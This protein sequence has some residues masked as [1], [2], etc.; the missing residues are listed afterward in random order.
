[1][2]EA[3]HSL[4]LVR[5]GTFEVDLQAGE[6][7]KSGLKLK[8]TGQPFQVLAILLERAGEVVTREEMQ[9]RLWPDTFV[10]VDHNLNT[11]INKI[12]EVLGDSAE[13]P[14]FVETL[15]RRGY[16]FIGTI[17]HEN[18]SASVSAGLERLKRFSTNLVVVAVMLLVVV[19]SA[20]IWLARKRDSAMTTAIRSIAVLPLANLSGD[21]Q[22]D[23]LADGVTEELIATLGKLSALRVISRT[24]VMRYKNTDKPLPQI[25][26][27]LNVDAVVEGSAQREGNRVRITAQLIHASTDR[28]LWAETYD[29]DLRDILTVESEVAQTIANEVRIK[30]TPQEQA[31][32]ASAPPV[33]PE[34]RE[35]YLKGRYYWNKRTPETAKKSLDYFQR[36]IEKD[37]GYA[38][39]YSA[40]ADSYVVLGAYKVL[41]PKLAYPKAEAAAMRAL[42]ADNRLG[43]AHAA[44]GVSKMLFDWNW[45][46]AE[47]EFK[48]AIELSPNYA[49]AYHWYA[50]YL[51]RMGRHTEAITAA[52]KAESLDPLSLVNS[53]DLGRDALGPA[54]LYE[55]ELQQCRKTLEMD[56]NFASAHVCLADSY[57]RKG[58]YKEAIAELQRANETS[59]GG[60][61]LA[62]ALGSAF[63]R[64]GRR[65][66]A[67]KILNQLEARSK[68]EFV[69][70]SSFAIMYGALG[71]R[72]QAFLWLE[73]G[74]E[75]HDTEMLN[76][77]SSPEFDPLRSD[78]RFEDLVRRMNLPQ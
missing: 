24:S 34:V 26:K 64:A 66:E 59:G 1:V 65:D 5:F 47:R 53:A 48:Q 77:R 42:E 58:M 19:V 13:N 57:R 72:D 30:L 44:L 17:N 40:L 8:L 46:G 36:A 29:R 20:A 32:L 18:A 62:P 31:G 74:Y 71:Q 4:S 70:A 22:Q 12:R 76:L 27:E 61:T 67:I 60:L 14:R 45:D 78:A 50:L 11:A 37:P 54:G 23:Y 39:A 56:P 52:R 73:K 2:E 38:P 63:A 6:L 21:P 68:R 55:Q 69:P 15:P 10:D 33:S 35:L 25:A 9:K 7:R 49:N 3:I 43:E 51:S 41:P 75:E 16:R 28:H